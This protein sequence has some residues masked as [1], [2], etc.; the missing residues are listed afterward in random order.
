MKKS[1]AATY[2]S[3]SVLLGMLVV[4]MI[5]SNI[6][7]SPNGLAL[8]GMATISQQNANGDTVFTQTVHNQLFDA[9]ED[10]LLDNAFTGL[11]DVADSIDIGSICLSADATPTSDETTTAAT[12]NADHDAADDVSASAALTNCRTD[13]TVTKS[14]Q[15]ATVGPLVFTAKADNNAGTHW[16]AGSG[17]ANTVTNIAI[18]DAEVIDNEIR[19]CTTTLFAVVNTSDVVLGVD[20]TVTVTYT[21]SLASAGT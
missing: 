18:C 21:F 12:W 14:A 6:A 1:A 9:G 11:T 8:Y 15:V 20:E 5:P 7:E 19:G 16:F 17:A 3:T 2:V 10:F 13:G 4:L